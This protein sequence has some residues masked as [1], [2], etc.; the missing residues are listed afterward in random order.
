[1]AIEQEYH[2]IIDPEIRVE[3]RQEAAIRPKSLQEYIG[4]EALKSQMNVFIRAAIKRRSCLNFWTSRFR[5]NN[6]SQY[7]CSRNE[8]EH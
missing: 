4:Q 3:D 5:K 6:F 2:N 1:M 7:H 8:C